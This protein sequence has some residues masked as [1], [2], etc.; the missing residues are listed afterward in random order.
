MEA[1]YVLATLELCRGSLSTRPRKRT[2]LGISL[3]S[4]EGEENEM[5]E[6]TFKSELLSWKFRGS[7]M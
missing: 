7:K 1:L 4:L 2:A 5:A 3:V 6:S